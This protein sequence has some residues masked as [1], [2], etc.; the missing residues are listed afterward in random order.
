MRVN[1]PKILNFYPLF[2]QFLVNF[3]SFWSKILQTVLF[4]KKEG[5]F[6]V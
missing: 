2:D 3:W 4:G 1:F 5:L 6:N